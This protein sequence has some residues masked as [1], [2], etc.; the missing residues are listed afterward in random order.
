MKSSNQRQGNLYRTVVVAALSNVH[1]PIN[2]AIPSS[3]YYTEPN[4]SGGDLTTLCGISP[5]R[6]QNSNTVRW[7]ACAPPHMRLH[8][9]HHL[10]RFPFFSFL[11]VGYT[12]HHQLLPLFFPPTLP[13][14]LTI[15][16]LK[17]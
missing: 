17:I 6:I 9:C 4:K 2:H 11:F 16:Y 10:T 12:Y 1:C 3:Q 8:T 5:H 15:N 13:F 7:G 14:T